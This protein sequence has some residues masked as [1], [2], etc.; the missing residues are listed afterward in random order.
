M[1][2]HESTTQRSSPIEC[3]DLLTA[4]TLALH[5]EEFKRA[6][7]ASRQKIWPCI[8]FAAEVGDEH[9]YTDLLPPFHLID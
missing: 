1:Q 6:D 3:M 9:L 8:V 2:L 7:C 5:P 4:L